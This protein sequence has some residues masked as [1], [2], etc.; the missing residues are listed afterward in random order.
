M[1]AGSQNFLTVFNNQLTQFMD[2]IVTILPNNPDILTAKNSI[3]L[4]RKTNPKL[5]IVIWNERIS[6]KYRS[7]IE[8]GDIDFLINKDYSNDLASNEHISKILSVIEGLREPIKNMTP[9]NRTKAIKYI[10]NLT[11]LSDLYF[12]K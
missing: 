4:I 11:K 6:S 10:Q 1:S 3:S 12:Q 5:I 7:Q 2:D 8:N 9:E